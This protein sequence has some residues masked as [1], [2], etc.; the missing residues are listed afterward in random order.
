MEPPRFPLVGSVCKESEKETSVN[1]VHSPHV[2]TMHDSSGNHAV[3][4]GVTTPIEWEDNVD[5]LATWDPVPL[6]VVYPSVLGRLRENKE[7]WVKELAVSSFVR[8][9]VTDGYRLPFFREP[10]PVFL[11]NHAS[12][13]HEV[14]FVEN[15]LH[16]LVQA[17]CI[18]R[19]EEQPVVCSPLS[20]V[21]SSSG[22]RR[23]VLDL[24]YVNTFLWKDRFKY[25]DIKTAIQMIDTGDYAITFDLKSGYHHVDIHADY[26]KYLGFSWKDQ[27]GVTVYYLFR[28]LPFGLATAPFVFTKLLRPLVKRW[29]SQGLKVVIYVDDGICAAATRKA[30]GQAA[31]TIRQDLAQSG[32][33]INEEK[34]VFDPRQ[35]VAW[36]GFILDLCQGNISIPEHR[37][38]KLRESLRKVSPCTTVRQIASIVGQI[39]SMSLGLGPIARLM[40][41]SLYTIINHRITWN[42]KVLWTKEAGGEIKFWEDNIESL[43]GKEMRYKAGA[44]RLVY[45]DASNTG[46][47]GYTVGIGSTVAQGQW[48]ESESQT[49]STWRELEAINRILQAYS[50]TLQG[51]TVKWLTDNQNVVRIIEHGSRKPLLQEIAVNIL[52]V[53]MGRAIRLEMAWVP[54]EENQ[55]ADYLSRLI[56]HDDWMVNPFIFQW[57]D[58]VWGP[59]TIDRF[60]THYNRQLA[61]YN[62]RFWNPE[63]EAVDAFTCNWEE[64]NNWLCPPVYLIPRVLRHAANCKAVATLVVPHW[65]SAPYWPMLCP[66]GT[67]LAGFVHRWLDIPHM[68]NVTLP[69]RRGANL[70]KAGQPNTG[71]LALRLDFML[72][73]R[74]FKAGFCMSREGV[75]LGC[76]TRWH[77]W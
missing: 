69:G 54:R 59:H 64:E 16:D 2:L 70:F 31:L 12:A 53:L 50:K 3:D 58:S 19:A 28:V 66:D 46:Y 51:E 22:K 61:R 73:P 30:A 52:S 5:D 42:D 24:R 60:A 21:R 36:L 27:Q 13:R 33:V 41:R 23:L 25:E 7:F 76:A 8:D 62:S 55:Q 45:S 11:K 26:W 17:G 48:S 29:R 68:I 15:A 57:L 40:T 71:V 63:S 4:I 49:S 65:P 75:C 35:I 9:I 77:K 44:V 10:P 14:Q 38:E 34:S 32:L 6:E 39:V 43:N 72:P 37:I 56:D 74:S 47:G 1:C 67:H 20:V 18:V